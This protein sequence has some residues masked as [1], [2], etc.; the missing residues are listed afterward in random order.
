MFSA[1]I[2]FQ[3]NDITTGTYYSIIGSTGIVITFYTTFLARKRSII[4]K[5]TQNIVTT[6]ECHNCGYKTIKKFSRGDYVFKTA[7]NCEKCS[8]PMLI[9]S[10]FAEEL[11]KK[12]KP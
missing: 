5:E 6:T 7:A 11:N 2:A 8:Q 12:S 9:T 10:I 1:L 3:R 4:K